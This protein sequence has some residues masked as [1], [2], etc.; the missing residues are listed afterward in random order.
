MFFAVVGAV[1]DLQKE[2]GQGYEL[3]VGWWVEP[4]EE[5]VARFI[6]QDEDGEWI[7][8]LEW[9]SSRINSR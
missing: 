4:F 8:N 6:K 2:A 1:N 3:A 7:F 9:N 5:E